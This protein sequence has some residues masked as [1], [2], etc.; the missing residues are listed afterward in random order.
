MH[1]NNWNMVG[2]NIPIV[3]GLLRSSIINTWPIET[4]S[5]IMVPPTGVK[6]DEIL[7]G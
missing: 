2:T 1:N 3:Y 7:V 4:K 6:A 5:A